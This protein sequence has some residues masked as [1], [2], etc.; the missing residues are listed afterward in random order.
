VGANNGVFGDPCVGTLKAL[1]I[2]AQCSPTATP[3]PAPTATPTPSPLPSGAG[4]QQYFK[5]EGSEASLGDQGAAT[6]CLASCKAYG[7]ANGN[8]FGCWYLDG[9]NGYARDCRIC[10]TA[11]PAKDVYPNDWGLALSYGPR[12]TPTPTPAPTPTPTPIPTPTPTPSPTPV[13]NYGCGALIP[14]QLVNGSFEQ[15][16][17]TVG[18]DNGIAQGQLVALK[19]WDNFKSVIGWG[20]G[21]SDGI[22]LWGGGF[23]GVA[24]SDGSVL[25]ELKGNM[26]GL[27]SQVFCSSGAVKSVSLDIYAR[28]PNFADNGV[29]VQ[30]DGATVLSVSPAHQ[31]FKTYTAPISAAAG[32]HKLTIQAI[33]AGNPT[34]GALIDNVRL[35]ALAPQA[36]QK[37]GV[38]TIVMAMSEERPVTDAISQAYDA[39]T[40]V[41][42]VKS[43]KVLMVK[44]LYD[45]G[46]SPQEYAFLQGAIQGLGFSLTTIAEPASG[47]SAVDVSG[48]DVVW[49]VNPGYPARVQATFD[50]LYAASRAQQA[51]VIL[52]GD[53]MTSGQYVQS[54]S[55]TLMKSLGNGT[56][57][58][59]TAIDNN[60]GQASYIV[61]Y[62][63]SAFNYGNDIDLS[64]VFGPT[65]ETLATA[66]TTIAGC[67]V[68]TPAITRY[69]VN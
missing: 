44:A 3:T 39:I 52:S 6:A 28:N 61:A 66:V 15:L 56:S 8:V 49:F 18:Q 54:E 29:V 1:A 38:E 33:A 35:S 68:S 40:Y 23:N 50:T 60:A 34:E 43:P 21:T 14:D 62:G 45:M 65:V 46:E 4:F 26:P 41:S 20:S 67:S 2:Q 7:A 24:P 31:F 9:T 13:V 32:L 16:N 17:S 58:C 12:P 42:P 37:A 48:Y 59:G 55:L 64:F 51:G 11:A 47:L 69:R 10:S 19:A 30:V 27:I 5:C 53:D 57:A 63:A 22:E 36:S 25:L